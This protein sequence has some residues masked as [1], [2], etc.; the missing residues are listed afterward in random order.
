MRDV[1]VRNNRLIA[2]LLNVSRLERGSAGSKYTA[3]QF[4]ERVDIAVKE[5]RKDIKERGVPEYQGYGSR[6]N[7][8]CRH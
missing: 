6:Y 1:C 5:Y 8:P 7:S 4:E 3:A 2:D